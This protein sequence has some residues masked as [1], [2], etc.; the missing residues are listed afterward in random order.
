MSRPSSPVPGVA[1]GPGSRR[2][3]SI[4]NASSG[5]AARCRRPCWRSPRHTTP[6]ATL[7]SEATS[8]S[9][10][11]VT[12]RDERELQPGIQ[13]FDRFATATVQQFVFL[14]RPPDA[15]AVNIRP[16]VLL[17]PDARVRVHV[18]SQFRSWGQPVQAVAAFEDRPAVAC[19]VDGSRR[20]LAR[21]RSSPSGSTAANDSAVGVSLPAAWPCSGRKARSR[22]NRSP[23]LTVVR[24][25]TRHESLA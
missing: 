2:E 18:E 4:V 12:S 1:S 19:Q 10:R 15:V 8:R 20:S 6:V 7:T 16:V 17:P 13:R 9:R 11:A 3:R 24:P 23:R 22:S 14:A 21:R 5:Q 25:P